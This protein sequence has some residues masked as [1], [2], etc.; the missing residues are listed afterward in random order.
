MR[1]LRNNVISVVYSLIRFCIIK[2]FHWRAFR[3]Y[4]I[5]RFSPNTSLYFTGRGEISL[6][7]YVTAHTHVRL[8]VGE[9]AKLIIDDNVRFNYGC[10]VTAMKYIHI[11][12]NVGFGPNVL[13]YDHD[14]DFRVPGGVMEKKFKKGSVTIGEDTWIG[15]NTIILRDTKIGANCVVAAGSVIKGNF[16]DKTLIVQKRDTTTR[17]IYVRD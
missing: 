1:R 7:K 15:A 9:N 12:K 14:H 3:F 17:Q 11:S 8:I 2:L 5:E 10:I 6:G 13:I 16:P 4:M